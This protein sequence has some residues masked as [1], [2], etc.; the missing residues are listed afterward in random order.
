MAKDFFSGSA[1]RRRRQHRSSAGSHRPF[2]LGGRNVGPFLALKGRPRGCLP[3]WCPPQQS[4]LSRSG[5]RL[6][7]WG[8]GVFIAARMGSGCPLWRQQ[9][10][11]AALSGP[12]KIPGGGGAR[13]VKIERFQKEQVHGNETPSSGAVYPRQE[14]QVQEISQCLVSWLSR[15]WLNQ[16][17]LTKQS[18]IVSPKAEGAT[19]L[20]LHLSARGPGCHLDARGGFLALIDRDR[21]GFNDWPAI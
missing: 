21:T 15:P 6:S 19:S 13:K 5:F 11:A 7:P 10:K 14:L 1:R 2:Q 3:S 18:W 16:G 9:I 12:R 8:G 17:L 20:G 4:P